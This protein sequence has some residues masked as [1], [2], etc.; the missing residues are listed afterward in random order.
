M[1]GNINLRRYTKQAGTWSLLSAQEEFELAV[2][3]RKNL[4]RE[5]MSKLILH[6]LR[7]VVKVAFQF[8]S[9]GMDPLDL[10]QEG[11]IGLM[12][13]VKKFDPYKGNRFISYAVW[14]IRAYIM[15]FIISNWSAV[16]IGTTQQQK[17]L[18]Y[19]IGKIRAMLTPEDGDSGNARKNIARELKV[20]EEEIAEIHQ[21]MSGRDTSLDT[22]AVS[23]S[24]S[25]LT[26]LDCLPD[27]SMDQEQ[28]LAKVEEA[29][30]LQK[31]VREAMHH[32]SSKEQF[33]IE[34]RILVEERNTLRELGGKLK[35]SPE[36][37]RQIEQG[38]LSELK[39]SLEGAALP[40]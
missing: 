25:D 12:Q 37:V 38:A 13:A 21:R 17:K 7:F 22:A 29:E 18:F 36:R 30:L 3:V 33:V 9:Y 2:R 32:L 1:S 6:N 40:C 15:K 4:D 24:D 10:I 16:K 26:L 34:K 35:L 27:D 14:W 28:K 8:Q 5:A 39:K 11:N 20:S 19:K 31:R 23:R